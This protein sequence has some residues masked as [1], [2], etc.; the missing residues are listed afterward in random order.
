M[1][2]VLMLCNLG[3]LNLALSDKRTDTVA[4]R[5]RLSVR[6]AWTQLNIIEEKSY[7]AEIAEVE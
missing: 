3:Y 2:I 6:D 4:V 1:T 5:L 7:S